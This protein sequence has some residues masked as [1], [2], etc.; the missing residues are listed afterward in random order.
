MYLK[1]EHSAG[2]ECIE[3]LKQ[4]KKNLQNFSYIKLYTEVKT[5]LGVQRKK[6]TFF[7]YNKFYMKK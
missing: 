7:L 5:V 2:T 3:N 4:K 6:I 1:N